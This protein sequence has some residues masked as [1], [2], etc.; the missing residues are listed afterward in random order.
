MYNT[1]RIGSNGEG[2]GDPRL[3]SIVAA[4]PVPI[5]Y[6]GRNPAYNP[7]WEPEYIPDGGNGEL[8]QLNPDY[9]PAFPEPEP[10]FVNDFV[11]LVERRPECK[12]VEILADGTWLDVT[13]EEDIQKAAR[14]LEELVIEETYTVTC[15]APVEVE[16]V[17]YKG[18]ESSSGGIANAVS[19]AQGLNEATVWITDVNRVKREMSHAEA[20]SVALT[21]GRVPRDA[22]LVRADALVKN[23]T[24]GVS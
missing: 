16:G 11:Q 20:M 21:I 17:V 1:G 14:D 22:F 10:E 12:D 19:I 15:E 13:T 24:G 7:D 6:W 4:W 9:D 18:G 23:N 3:T 8:T 5:K 2:N